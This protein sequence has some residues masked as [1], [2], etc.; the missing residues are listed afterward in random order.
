[1]PTGD[2]AAIDRWL[3]AVEAGSDDRAVRPAAIAG[4]AGVA[5][6][7]PFLARLRGLLVASDQ[8][9]AAVRAVLGAAPAERGDDVLTLLDD[10][11]S[12][13]DL[14]HDAPEAAVL[15]AGRLARRHRRAA[16]LIARRVRRDRAQRRIDALAAVPLDER[17]RT[18]RAVPSWAFAAAARSAASEALVP[19]VILEMAAN[20]P[21]PPDGWAEALVA[22]AG[23]RGMDML[24][25]WMR[26]PGQSHGG[27]VGAVSLGSAG[28]PWRRRFLEH[29]D[30]EL[31]I[32][33]ARAAHD[34]GQRER[35][36]AAVLASID[37]AGGWVLHGGRHLDRKDPAG[38]D[39]PPPPTPLEAVTSPVADLR[40][41]ALDNLA[42]QPRAEHLLALLLA[43]ELDR[44]IA[45]D[46][47]RGR[48]EPPDTGRWLP[49]LV[50]PTGSRRRFSVTSQPLV[51]L[52]DARAFERDLAVPQRLTP[53]LEEL[54][55]VGAAAFATRIAAPVRLSDDERARLEAAE[56]A[57]AN[58]A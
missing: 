26:R 13:P 2:D 41:R 31:R 45:L 53:D 6:L 21:A 7:A 48:W 38:L 56:A 9:R 11:L 3:G 17:V 12:A 25:D 58:E 4:L 52:L 43:A 32:A 51:E 24:L 33:A 57:L 44:H 8:T 49:L 50:T 1:M 19:T 15:I 18:A 30:P 27:L 37:R 14:V 28:E 16:A 5:T 54:R 29:A 55:A 42:R 10:L 47:D 39:L 35:E 36:L 23:D 46:V 34:S 22:C 40:R 20:A